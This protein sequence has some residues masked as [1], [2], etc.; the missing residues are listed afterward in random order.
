MRPLDGMRPVFQQIQKVNE[1]VGI[2]ASFENA[3]ESNNIQQILIG[4][5]EI[6]NNVPDE[7]S[8]FAV[9]ETRF[10]PQTHTHHMVTGPSNPTHP[11]VTG[12]TTQTNQIPEFLTGRILTPRNSPS[13][14]NPNLSTQVSQDTNLTMVEQTPRTQN[15]DAYIS[16]NLLADA[17]ED[18][19][20]QQRRQAATML[21]PVPTNTLIFDGKNEKF[22]LFENFLTQC[23]KRN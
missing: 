16:I 7:I 4:N 1:H 18:I 10:D 23:S 3:S 19:A 11:M 20:T 22:E 6:R 2:N 8:E 5:D 12:Q 15:L 9:P 14:Q 21:K 17:I 13:H